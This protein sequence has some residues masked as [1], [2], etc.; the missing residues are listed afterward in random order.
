MEE[1]VRLGWTVGGRGWAWRP[2]LLA[3][4]EDSMREYILL[5]HNVVLQDNVSDTWRW[6]LDPV[7]G[8]SVREAYRFLIS[9]EQVDKTLVD[10]V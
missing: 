10:D 9:D 1:M 2:R 7:H 6:L 5:L 3:W 4:E 8:Y